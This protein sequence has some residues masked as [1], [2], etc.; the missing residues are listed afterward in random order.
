[1]RFS[2]IK[3]HQAR[4]L[5][6]V[7]LAGLA[8]TATEAQA[9]FTRSNPKAIATQAGAQQAPAQPKVDPNAPKLQQTR[10]PSSPNDTVA[11]V[12]NQIITRQ[13]LA[14]EAV[15][16]KGEEILDTLI[17]RVMIDQALKSKGIA[18]TADEV[19]AEI[20]AVAQRMAGLSREAWLR[21]LAKERNI[22]PIQ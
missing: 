15:A 6:M 21:T 17:A 10:I 18:V 4:Y 2:L 9:Q 11:I 16:R 12:N 7:T 22:S 19:N 1:M 13:Q 3:R 20:E 5:T 14:D 8:A